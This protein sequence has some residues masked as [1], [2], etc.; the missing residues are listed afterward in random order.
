MGNVRRVVQFKQKI[1]IPHPAWL[2]TNSEKHNVTTLEHFNKK[3]SLV[4]WGKVLKIFHKMYELV[5]ESGTSLVLEIRRLCKVK[6]RGLLPFYSPQVQQSRG[7]TTIV[8]QSDENNKGPTQKLSPS[9][10]QWNVGSSDP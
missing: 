2:K 6:K 4:L 7:G 10:W 5:E 8:T 9:G 3:N 1:S